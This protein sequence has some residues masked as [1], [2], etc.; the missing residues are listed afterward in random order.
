[1]LFPDKQLSDEEDDISELVGDG[2]EE[3]VPPLLPTLPLFDNC[4][5]LLDKPEAS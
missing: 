2:G 1:M 3:L 5:F 4:R